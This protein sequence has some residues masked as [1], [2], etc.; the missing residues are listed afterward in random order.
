L[1]VLFCG[2]FV[3]ASTAFSPDNFSRFF[4]HLFTL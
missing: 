1:R 3:P 4:F 2:H